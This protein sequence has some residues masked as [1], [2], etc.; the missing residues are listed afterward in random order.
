MAWPVILMNTSSKVGPRKV[1][2]SNGWRGFAG[3]SRQ[4]LIAAGHREGYLVVFDTRVDAV[5]LFE[6]DD[7]RVHC[8]AALSLTTSPP[9]AALRFAGVSSATISPWSMM[10]M[11][12]QYSASSM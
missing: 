6:L 2:D 10:A 11:R 12:S 7:Q 5:T 3:E 4:P 8:L 1:S 9:I